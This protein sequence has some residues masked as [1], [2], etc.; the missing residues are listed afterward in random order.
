[1]SYPKRQRQKRLEDLQSQLVHKRS[2]DE[3]PK[4]PDRPR[5]EVERQALVEQRIQEAM[6]NG[7][8]D[9]LPGKGKPLKLNRN[10]YLE[11]GLELAFGLLKNNGFAPE[12]IERDKE[13]RRDLG[14]ARSRLRIAWQHRNGSAGE[15]GWQTALT[16]FEA[17]LPRINRKIV[18]FNLVVP[19]VS[20][21]RPR[22]RL[23]D[24]LRRLAKEA[25]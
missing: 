15:A 22:L 2:S 10:P 11:P 19:I 6:A 16:R 24:E 25:E 7:A 12:W 1:M 4:N 13:I 23:A 20:C 8:F 14:A 3:L 18:D 21:Q 17:Q 9:H 5:N